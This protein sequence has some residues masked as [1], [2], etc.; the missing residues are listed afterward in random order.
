MLIGYHNM[1]DADQ[2]LAYAK[3][4]AMYRF[5]ENLPHEAQAHLTL[6][7]PTNQKD[8]IYRTEQFFNSNGWTI[9]NYKGAGKSH[10]T[11]EGQ[12]NGQQSQ[13][14]NYRSPYN[15]G[16][17]QHHQHQQQQADQDSNQGDGRGYRAPYQPPHRRR[18]N[19]YQ[20][21]SNQP[22]NNTQQPRN[23][24]STPNNSSANPT[25]TCFKCGKQGFIGANC[26]A[27]VNVNILKHLGSIS[28]DQSVMVLGVVCGRPVR[29]IMLDT[30]ADTRV[31][32]S[33]LV[34]DNAREEGIILAKG[35]GTEYIPCPFVS[36]PVTVK[37]TS[38][39]IKAIVFPRSVVGW[40]VLLG[41]DIPGLQIIWHIN[42]LPVPDQ[43]IIEELPDQPAPQ[44][45]QLLA[46]PEPSR[47]PL[48]GMEA[49]LPDRPS[50]RKGTGT[51]GG[52]TNP[53][54]EP[55]KGGSSQ[56]W[57]VPEALWQAITEEGALP[58]QNIN[59]FTRAQSKREDADLQQLKQLDALSTA[60]PHPL[61]RYDQKNVDVP[62]L[63]EDELPGNPFTEDERITNSEHLVQLQLEDPTLKKYFRLAQLN[64]DNYYIYN[65]VL[66]IVYID[67][68]GKAR[69][70]VL[71][72]KSLRS[73]IFALAH[74][75][76]LSGHFCL[77]KTIDIIYKHFT[78]PNIYQDKELVSVL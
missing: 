7:D 63:P 6:T 57:I 27:K 16:G 70:I 48:E 3:Q 20:N 41:R 28:P 15:Q 45:S 24:N 67:E 69:K 78:W 21:N 22:N 72:P 33:D 66:C 30:G 31:V 61:D 18:E 55:L 12:Y 40:D 77:E 60:N 2:N 13:Q 11:R 37:G 1:P 26:P 8:T 44:S 50:G 51:G 9:T 14:N 19:N 23:Q 38:V 4:A 47:K 42:A 53:G 68:F 52:K 64:Q 17:Q 25:I 73:K 34:P 74:K 54:L 39:D 62:F 56:D 10:S 43:P 46:L 29:N 59:I 58:V 75:S 36:I 35:I 71:A 49:A 76:L 32:S 65:N 5:R